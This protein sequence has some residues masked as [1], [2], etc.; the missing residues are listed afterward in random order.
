MS[1][2]LIAQGFR[3]KAIAVEP[4]VHAIAVEPKL[5]IGQQAYLVHT[6]QGNIMWDCVGLL[7]PQFVAEVEAL[8]GV[9][10]IAVSHPHFYAACADWA[11]AF[12]AHRECK[13]YLHEADR[14]WVTRPST[15]LEFW[16]GEEREV[17]TGV[18]LMQ[19]GGHFPGSSVLLW[20]ESRDGQGVVF[21]GDTVFPV[22]GGGVSFMFSF[23]N[24]L[25]LP[26]DQVARIGRTLGR[27]NFDRLY[28]PFPQSVVKHDA[29][30]VVR[31]SAARYC[32]LLDGSTTRRYT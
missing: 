5:G 32:G 2:E 28:G 20:E 30:A 27:C 22:P 3:N 13:V 7:H 23:P 31:E 24:L 19:L 17:W 11:E 26:V 25:P 29:A 16:S 14:E 15:A 12:S 18:N 1:D 9:A 8:G 4:G 10:A 6:P 21:A